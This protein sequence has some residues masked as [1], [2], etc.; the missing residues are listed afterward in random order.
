M[1]GE[2]G[3]QSRLYDTQSLFTG[4][5]ADFQE[6]EGNICSVGDGDLRIFTA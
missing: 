2:P 3:D 6:E 1:D 5:T 4:T